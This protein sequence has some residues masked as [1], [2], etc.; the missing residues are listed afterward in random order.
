MI[1]NVNKAI[2]L[3]ADDS[4]KVCKVIYSC[5]TEDQ[6]NSAKNMIQLFDKKWNMNNMLDNKRMLTLRCFWE[7]YISACTNQISAKLGIRHV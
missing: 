6:Y 2:E 7:G 3:M 1:V 5:K 4:I